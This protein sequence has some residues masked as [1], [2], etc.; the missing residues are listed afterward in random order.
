[1]AGICGRGA[2]PAA[3]GAAQCQLAWVRRDASEPRVWQNAD[4]PAHTVVRVFQERYVYRH[5]APL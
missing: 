5:P 3:L 2:K 1:M 4:R